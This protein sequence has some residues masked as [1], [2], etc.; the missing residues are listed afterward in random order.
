[1]SDSDDSC[2]SGRTLKP[3]PELEILIQ[4]AFASYE[5]ADGGTKTNNNN[6]T[7]IT[8]PEQ[9]SFFVGIHINYKTE[10][11]QTMAPKPEITGFT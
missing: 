11:P 8:D 9:R 7:Y 10:V 6:Y 1:M 5:R 2:A 4:E 3:C